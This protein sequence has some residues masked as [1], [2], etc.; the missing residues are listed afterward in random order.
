MLPKPG[1]SPGT[2]LVLLL[3]YTVSPVTD[4]AG[5]TELQTSC[6]GLW[7]G[8]VFLEKRDGREWFLFYVNDI[9]LPVFQ[10]SFCSIG[11][12]PGDFV[13]ETSIFAN[14]CFLLLIQQLV[15]RWRQTKTFLKGCQSRLSEVWTLM[16]PLALCLLEGSMH[17]YCIEIF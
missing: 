17:A 4:A 12:T 8:Q 13:Q 3:L 6:W 5:A 10:T 1:T 14:N 11:H 15:I 16:P 9:S 2:F 7:K